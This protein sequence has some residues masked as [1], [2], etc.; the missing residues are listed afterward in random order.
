MFI[1]DIDDK[2]EEVRLDALP[3]VEL[4]NEDQNIL[5]VYQKILNCFSDAIEHLY[6]TN[7]PF[8]CNKL[9]I[10]NHLVSRYVGNVLFRYMLLFAST[11]K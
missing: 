2:L 7:E 9:V 1:D 5:K 3:D 11:T 10:K 4:S 6:H 8:K